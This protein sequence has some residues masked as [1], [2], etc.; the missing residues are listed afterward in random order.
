MLWVL[1]VIII[2]LYINEVFTA[3]EHSQ[4]YRWTQK[5]IPKISIY[6]KDTTVYINLWSRGTSHFT[7][8]QVA[9]IKFDAQI[10]IYGY[11]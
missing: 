2:K 3:G 6:S 7:S 4:I 11:T 1:T 10:T 5:R 8:G 9:L